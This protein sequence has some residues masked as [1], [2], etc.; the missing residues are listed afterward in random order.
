M[1]YTIVESKIHPTLHGYALNS[2]QI[3]DVTRSNTVYRDIMTYI[4]FE[5]AQQIMQAR[6]I[7][8]AATGRV[9]RQLKHFPL[10]TEVQ[11]KT[12]NKGMCVISLIDGER[13]ALW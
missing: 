13:H 11:M 6:P 8:L 3:M 12:D 9:S 7:A 4:E 2:F 1:N 5:L 10:N